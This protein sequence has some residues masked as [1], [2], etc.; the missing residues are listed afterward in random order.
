MKK[1]KYISTII[2]IIVLLVSSIGLWSLYPS[3]LSNAKA[4]N[5]D[6]LMINYF[7]NNTRFYDYIIDKNISNHENEYSQYFHISGGQITPYLQQQQ[8]KKI[9]DFYQKEE[10]LKKEKNIL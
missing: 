7:M 3:I 10:Q 2:I 1:N 9:N 4:K 6:D 8:D 5:Y